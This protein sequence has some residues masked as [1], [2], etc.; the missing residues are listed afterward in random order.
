VRTVAQLVAEE[1]T[2]PA[3]MIQQGVGAGDE[4]TYTLGAAVRLRNHP[5][6]PAGAVP[7]LGEHTDTVLDALPG[8]EN[9]QAAGAAGGRDGEQTGGR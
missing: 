2:R 5:P 6:R 1:L 7:S 8:G 9:G 4:P 3:P